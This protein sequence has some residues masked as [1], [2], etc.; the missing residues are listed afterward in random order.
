MGSFVGICVDLANLKICLFLFDNVVK[1]FDWY[2]DDI[3]YY[4]MTY[5]QSELKI[6]I[7]KGYINMVRSGAP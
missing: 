3:G 4:Y 6:I 7:L 2:L 1:I 5:G